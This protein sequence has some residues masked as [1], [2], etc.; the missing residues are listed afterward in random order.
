MKKNKYIM[1][2][3]IIIYALTFIS[4]FLFDVIQNDI[5]AVFFNT[6]ESIFQHMKMVFTCFFVFYFILFIVRRRFHFENVFLT[7]LIASISCIAFFLIIY[8]PTYLRFGENMIFTFI[9][10]WISIL[11]GQYI[12]SPILKKTDYKK[13]EILSIIIISLIFVIGGYLTY[14]PIENF[15]FWD[16]QHETYE[17][18]LK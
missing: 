11:F 18:V 12:S 2:S 13:T 16:P 15:I 8:I 7:N 6:N 5:I 1:I 14:Y 3:S 4:H 10:L 17:R 9:L